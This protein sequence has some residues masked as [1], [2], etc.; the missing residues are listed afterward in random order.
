M[1]DIDT[2]IDNLNNTMLKMS[3]AISQIN[4]SITETTN[5]VNNVVDNNA[6]IVALTTDTY[7]MVEKTIAYSDSLKEIVDSFTL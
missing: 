6:N 5:G 4:S 3:D 1:S 7:N 2:S